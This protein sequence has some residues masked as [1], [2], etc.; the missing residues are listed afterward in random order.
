M[1]TAFKDMLWQVLT[2]TGEFVG[3]D[4]KDKPCTQVEEFKIYAYEV[5]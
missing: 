2:L 4:P 5:C 1:R 3:L